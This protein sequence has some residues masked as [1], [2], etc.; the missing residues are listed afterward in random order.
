MD[1]MLPRAPESGLT[2]IEMMIV[3]VVLATTLSMGA[4]LFQSLLHNHRLHAEASRFLGAINLARSEAVMRNL[5]V[6][7]CPSA[8]ATTGKAQC[9]GTYAGGWIVFSNMDKDKVVDAG[10]DEVL[11]VFESL[12]PGYRLTNRSSSKAAFE[13]INYLPDGSSHSNRTLLFCP[14]L[15]T[16]GQ[17]QSIIINIVGRARLTGGWGECPTV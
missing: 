15:R 14:P 7:I 16:S 10:T 3:L 11:Q 4:P 17:S 9:S 13:L 2:L 6:S 5:P 1:R 8:M 12:P